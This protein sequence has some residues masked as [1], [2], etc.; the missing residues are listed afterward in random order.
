METGNARKV[1]RRWDMYHIVM[2]MASKVSYERRVVICVAY[3]L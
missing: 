1:F 2:R 3:Y